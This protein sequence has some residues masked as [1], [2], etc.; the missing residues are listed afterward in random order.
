[1]WSIYYKII[2][3]QSEHN[4]Y[5]AFPT[6]WLKIILKIKNIND[7]F[8]KKLLPI[9]VIVQLKSVIQVCACISVILLSRKTR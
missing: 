4:Y 2:A 8:I 1:M 6:I 9:K 7:Q 5:V 3:Y